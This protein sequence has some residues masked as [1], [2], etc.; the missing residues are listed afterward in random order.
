MTQAS[1][2][3]KLS[4]AAISQGIGTR[5]IGRRIHVFELVISTNDVVWELA[6]RGAAEGT[7]VFA[8]GQTGG[9]GRLGRSWWSP[10]SKGIWMSVLLRPP[11]SG[12][13][14]PMTTIIGAL[15]T[16]D[17]I[18]GETNL[19]AF[20]RW[21]NDVLV[22]GRKVAGVL[23][24]ARDGAAG[25]ELVLGIGIDVNIDRAEIPGE[26]AAVAAAAAPVVK[27]RLLDLHLDQ[28]ARKGSVKRSIFCVW[29]L[30]GL[31]PIC[32]SL[33]SD[34]AALPLS[35]RK[36]PSHLLDDGDLFFP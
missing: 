14:I 29:G 5:I 34:Q 28:L 22:D 11:R 6:D 25:R 7:V 32:R 19:P 2:A 30:G 8:E 24:E 12:G 27:D 10:R 13:S 16:A 17:A 33:F 23:V 21:P 26:L 9:R 18:R 35:L 20:I 31:N 3:D 36:E 15:A 4:V 1:A